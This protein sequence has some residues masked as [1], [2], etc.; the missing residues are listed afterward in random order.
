MVREKEVLLVLTALTILA[1]F[2][3]LWFIP[4]SPSMVISMILTVVFPLKYR[5]RAELGLQRPERWRHFLKYVALGTI[6]SF[7]VVVASYAFYH[8]TILEN[9]GL[10]GDIR[11]DHF[12][13]Y[14]SWI[15][16]T[17]RKFGVEVAW[18]WL[19]LFSVVW[20]PIGEELLYR[21]YA[22]N[23]LL[24]KRSFVFSST[25]S[26]LYFGVRHISH[27]LAM[28]TTPVIPSLFW[29]VSVIPFGYIACYIFHKTRSLYSV[30][31]IHFILNLLGSIVLYS[32]A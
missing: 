26:S 21:G 32:Y 13:A 25:I 22:F 29:G 18:T 1:F 30:M 31:L 20:A 14:K 9:L 24:E 19:L 28:P 15:E 5:R 6:L 10:L 4:W 12:M 7:F 27:L 2:E 16:H 8:Y 17:M 3:N 11:Y 23:S